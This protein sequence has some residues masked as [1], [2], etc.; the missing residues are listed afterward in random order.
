MVTTA[1]CRRAI[2]IALLSAAVAPTACKKSPS[3]PPP[4]QQPAAAPPTT[5]SAQQDSAAQPPDWL[6]HPQASPG[7]TVLTAIDPKTLSQ[8]EVRFGIA[9]K[10]SPDVEYQPG[11]IVMEHGDQAI[12]AAAGDGMSWTFDANAPN[13]GDFQE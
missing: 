12:R 11:V 8:S 1:S 10:R 9:P 4:P 6:D 5:G 7:T 3:P 2:A 13:V